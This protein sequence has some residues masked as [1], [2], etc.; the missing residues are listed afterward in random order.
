[1]T[2]QTALLVWFVV[3]IAIMTFYWL[4]A[5]R[6]PTQQGSEIMLYTGILGGFVW[7]LIL[8]YLPFFGLFML[9]GWLL[10][11]S[12]TEESKNG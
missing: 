4:E 7:P 8:I 2:W 11:K 6:E 1:M 9:A 12:D 10:G 3:W 5:L